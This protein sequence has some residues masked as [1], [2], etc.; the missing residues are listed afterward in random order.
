M[1]GLDVVDSWRRL[2]QW[3]SSMFRD[4]LVCLRICNDVDD[5]CA[6]SLARSLFLCCMIC[7]HHS[8]TKIV[9]AQKIFSPVL[10]EWWSSVEFTFWWVSFLIYQRIVVAFVFGVVFIESGLRC[11]V[12]AAMR[13]W[14]EFVGEEIRKS[15]RTLWS[16]FFVSRVFYDRWQFS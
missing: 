10:F 4:S 11:G 14:I 12:W 6:L 15:V 1:I 13:S 7:Y 16:L 2:S 5:V 9:A 8:M 3:R